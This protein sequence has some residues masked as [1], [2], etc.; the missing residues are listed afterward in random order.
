MTTTPPPGLRAAAARNCYEEVC[1]EARRLVYDDQIASRVTERRI[2]LTDS[3]HAGGERAHGDRLEIVPVRL[4]HAEA[5]RRV[6]DTIA[7][8]RRYLPVFEA[9]PL[10]E[11]RRYI[12]DA[13]EKDDPAVIALGDDAVVGWCNIRRDAQPTGAHRGVLGMGVVPSWRRRGVGSRLIEA[14]LRLARERCFVRIELEVYA[15][16]HPA[17]ALYKKFG[18]APEGVRRDAIAIDGRYCDAI[19]LA[20]VERA[21]I[22]D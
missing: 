10:D 8:E 4:R 18:F 14:A 19:L 13:I 3:M 16:N 7:R 2:G 12:Q 21:N 1:W 20:I 22:P 15:D 17:I 11:V 6:F 9:P 5:L